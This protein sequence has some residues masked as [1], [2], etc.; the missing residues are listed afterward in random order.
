M[1]REVTVRE[2]QGLTFTTDEVNTIKSTVAKDATDT[3]LKLFLMQCKR[4][5]LDPFSRQIYFFKMGGKASIQASI[6]GFRLIAERSDKYEGQTIPLYLDKEGTWH[7]VWLSDKEFPI[8]AKVGVYKKGFRDPLYAIAKWS[9][10]APIY[11][12]QVG[13]MWKKMPEVMLAKVAEALALRKAFPNDLSGIYASEEMSQAQKDEAAG[14]DTSEIAEDV[15]PVVTV[16]DQ[17]QPANLQE[18]EPQEPEI[19]TDE[20]A[21]KRLI[22]ALIAKR[23][24]KTDLKDA[25]EMKRLVADYTELELVPANFVSIIKKLR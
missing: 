13:T 3:E 23:W 18:E 14:Y 22:M 6:D 17:E 1:N 12:G 19:P 5:G 25:K 4:T 10:Y 24:P 9:S 8:A 7:E 20:V 15:V 21:Q 16:D 11:N 2:N